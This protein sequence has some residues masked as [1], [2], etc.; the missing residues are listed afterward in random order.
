M[1]D[2]KCDA[3]GDSVDPRGNRCASVGSRATRITFSAI[4]VIFFVA[5][6]GACSSGGQGDVNIGS[7]QAADPIVLDFPIA[8]VQRALPTGDEDLRELRTVQ[9]GADVWLRDRA[10]PAAMDRNLTAGITNGEWD[11]RDLDV[12]FDG[13]KLAFAMRAPLIEGA[14]ESEQPTWNIYEYDHSAGSLRRVITSDLVAEEGHDVAPHYLPDGRIVFASSRQRQS[15]GTLTDEG[16]PQFSAL[17]EDRNEWAFVLHVMSADGS[18]IRQISFNQSHDLDPSVLPDG[19]IVFSRWDN[20]AGS[21]IHLYAVRPDSS[22][23]ELLYGVNS[24]DTG[25]GNSIIQFTTPRARPDGKVV[26]LVRPFGDTELGGD[27]VAIDTGT[28]VENSQPTLASA[29][30]AGPAQARLTSNDVRTV[31]G[32]SP[33]GRYAAAYPLW[34]GTDRLL[35][36]W[37]L[38]RVVEQGRIQPCTSERLANPANTPAAPLYGIFIW[39]PRDSTQRPVFEP[40][41]GVMFTDVAALAPRSPLPPVI[42]D[43]VAGVDYDT[44]LATENVGIL[45]IRSVYDLDGVD[46]APGGIATLRDPALTTADQRPAR[47]LRIEK[48]VGIPD[49][50]VRDIRGTAFGAAGGLGMREILAYAPIEP[51]GSV[52]VK[53]PAGVPFAVSVTDRDGRR[54]SPR[55]L[56]WLQLRAGETRTCDGCHV[57]AAAQAAVPALSHGR[58]ELFA[59][60]NPGAPTTGQPFPNTD[61]ALFA[62]QGESMAETRARISCQTDCAAIV[63]SVNVV[64]QDVWTDPV[65]AGRA[66]DVAI[67]YLYSDLQTPAPA[68][69][70]CQQSWSSLCRIVIHYPDH[71]QPLWDLER[72]V[73][74]TDGITVL[75]DHSC[76]ACHSP[77]DAADLPRVPA[78][79]LDLSGD[80]SPEQADHFVSYRDLLFGDNEQELVMGALQDILVPGP[81]DP[82]TGLPTQVPVAVPAAM[83]PAGALASSRFFSRFETGGSHAGYLSPAELRLVAEWLDIGAQY[84]NDPFAA[85]AD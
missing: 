61:P 68:R 62:D 28:Y 14:Q 57:P 9:G 31:P 12:S 39:D 24:H 80:P 16:K 8:Y 23:L 22:G 45:H 69:P 82:V 20:A 52:M 13:S 74:D 1:K 2:G 81:P 51:D 33:G 73:L 84:Y 30:L 53:V 44:E 38:C 3:G 26:S 54:I 47:F 36:S 50:E 71:I 76:L 60:V 37:S 34:D 46:A 79:Q 7:G 75:E 67:S 83:S 4:G 77:R 48:A 32:P 64:F 56:N 58:S 10:A 72:L 49:D 59:S 70:D 41:E 15:R 5:T 19:R 35:V 63:P 29:G 66:P 18:S 25:S 85:P 43:A 21:A 78:G 17:D 55:H 27:P 40:V 11:V 6:L 65:A 42:L